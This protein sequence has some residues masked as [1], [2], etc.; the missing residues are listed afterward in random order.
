[1]N[2]E[3]EQKHNITDEQ[4]AR[5]LSGTASE[6]EKNAILEYMS[7]SDENID[8]L[9]SIADAVQ[10]Q[11]NNHQA[12]KPSGNR[13]V[14]WRIAASVAVIL[15]A[16]GAWI[17]LRDHGVDLETPSSTTVAMNTTPAPTPVPS[18]PGT[19]TVTDNQGQSDNQTIKQPNNK[20]S[21]TLVADAGADIDLSR[22][23][24]EELHGG[25]Q[26]RQ[27]IS[28]NEGPYMA[29]LTTGT[30]GQ[31]RPETER[32]VLPEVPK[33]WLPGTDLVIKWKTDAP[34]I[35]VMVKPQ[36]AKYWICEREIDNTYVNPR[37]WVTSITISSK[38]RQ[39]YALYNNKVVWR[40]E[41]TFEDGKREPQ[42]RNGI[43]DL[44][45]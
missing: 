20:S 5:F 42:P 13:T 3:M 35:K 22:F 30:S 41:A 8:E 27:T 7:Q 37:Q 32:I 36:G 26:T 33:Q 9:M 14:A 25:A 11:R 12:V 21:N 17:L 28:G 19:V 38:E 4:I 1:M 24:S 16:G 39:D 6:E 34:K 18:T 15:L 45:K 43:I 2:S 31:S 40:I 29:S 44:P 10:A 23:Q